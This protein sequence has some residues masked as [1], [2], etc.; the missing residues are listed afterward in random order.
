TGVLLG[1]AKKEGLEGVCLMG[2]TAG[3]PILTDP[4]AAE[5]VVK[6]LSDILDIDIPLDEMDEKVNEMEEFLEKLEKIQKKAMKKRQKE[7]D[8]EEKLKYI[9]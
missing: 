4:K 6:I 9:G 2:E 1:T 7:S 8:E 5:S 3:F